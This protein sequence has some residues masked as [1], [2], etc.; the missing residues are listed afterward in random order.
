[1]LQVDVVNSDPSVTHEDLAW[2]G[3]RIRALDQH[4]LLGPAMTG[5]LDRQHYQL[6]SS[7]PAAPGTAG[8]A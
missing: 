2:R 4:E 8:I 7:G 3:H 5:D 1:M 6:L